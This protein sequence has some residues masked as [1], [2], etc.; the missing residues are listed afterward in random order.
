MCWEVYLGSDVELPW[1]EWDEATHAFN[2]QPLSDSEERVRIQFSLPYV[3]Y[4][5]SHDGC[6]CGFF[7]EEDDEPEDKKQRDEDARRL[8]D[9]LSQA[10]EA[11]A[12][13]EMFLCWQGGEIEPQTGRRQLSPVDFLASQFPLNENEFAT[14]VTSVDEQQRQHPTPG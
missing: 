10:L 12:K 6:S 8:S 14:I 7:A 2:T 4:L 3:I 13:L 9:Y 11:G 1:V 5:G